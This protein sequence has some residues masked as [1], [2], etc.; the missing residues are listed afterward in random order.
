MLWIAI[1]DA[2]ETVIILDILS[3]MYFS[4][5]I[6]YNMFLFDDFSKQIDNEMFTLIYI[7]AGNNLTNTW[8]DHKAHKI[9]NIQSFNVKYLL[10]LLT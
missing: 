3:I 10:S 9:N 1:D 2:S 6:S 5:Q 8:K 4:M 7:S